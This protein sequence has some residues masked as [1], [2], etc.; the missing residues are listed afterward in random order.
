MRCLKNLNK[1]S[2]THCR[3]IKTVFKLL[4]N[5]ELK[6]KWITM[7]QKNL[8]FNEMYVRHFVLSALFFN[9]PKNSEVTILEGLII[10]G[11]TLDILFICGD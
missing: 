11:K 5:K 9:I 2:S 10:N 1:Y 6:L 3:D 7:L 4:S 8:R